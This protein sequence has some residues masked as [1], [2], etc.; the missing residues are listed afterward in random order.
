MVP[1][2]SIRAECADT[3]SNKGCGLQPVAF[4]WLRSTLRPPQQHTLPPPGCPPGWRLGGM[5]AAGAG[6]S[7]HTQRQPRVLSLGSTAF[8]PNSPLRAKPMHFLRH[9][10]CRE[11]KQL[12]LYSLP[13]KG[14]SLRP[15]GEISSKEYQSIDM[16]SDSLSEKNTNAAS[17]LSVSCSRVTP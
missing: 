5:K 3:L 8:T 11:L 17:L 2:P 12:P 15:Q 4:L 7:E 9:S 6:L 16:G 1:V 10:S 14:S 13:P